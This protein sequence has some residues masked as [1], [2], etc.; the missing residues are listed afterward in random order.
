MTQLLVFQYTRYLF[1]FESGLW[2]QNGDEITLDVGLKVW[3]IL[4]GCDR[5]YIQGL[6]VGLGL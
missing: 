2:F 5:E 3:G 4:E 6:L 1:S